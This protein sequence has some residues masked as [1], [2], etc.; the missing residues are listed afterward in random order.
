MHLLCICNPTL[1]WRHQRN[2]MHSLEIEIKL[3]LLLIIIDVWFSQ[4]QGWWK[5][6]SD[7]SSSPWNHRK[8]FST[9]GNLINNLANGFGLYAGVWLLHCHFEMHLSWGMEMAFVVKN[10]VGVNQTLPPPPDDMP[11]CKKQKPK[12]HH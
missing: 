5:T 6:E 1:H 2:F 10:G 9:R 7:C 11:R 12:R 8:E 4:K 3:P